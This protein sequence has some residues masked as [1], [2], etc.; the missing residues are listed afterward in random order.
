MTIPAR[1]DYEAVFR[2]E[3]ERLNAAQRAAVERTE[4]PV[5]VLAG[6]G[7]GKTHL[8]AARIGNILLETDTGAHNILCLTFT[9]AGAKAMRDRLLSFIGP[10]AHRIGIFTFHGFCSRVIQDNLQYFGRPGLEPLGELE[11]VRI[12]RRLLDDLPADH[13]LRKGYHDVYQHEQHLQHLFSAM[14]AENWSVDQVTEAVNAFDRGLDTHPDYTYRNNRKGQWTKGDPKTGMIAQARLAMAKLLGGVELFPAYQDALRQL[15]R[16][17]YGDMIGWVL[18]AFHDH[19]SLLR[20]YQERYQY[21]LVD[22]FQDTNGSQDAIV[23]QLTAYWEKPNVFIVGDDDQAIYEFQGARLQAMLDFFHRHEDVKVVTLTENYR[24]RQPIL[25]AAATLISGNKLRIA[26]QLKEVAVDKHLRSGREFEDTGSDPIRW[27]SFSDRNQETAGLLRQLRDWS[28]GGTPWGEMAVIYARHGQADLLRHLL[29]RAGIPYQSKRRPNVLDGRPVRQ[30]REMLRYLNAEFRRPGTGEHLL[31]RILHNRFFKTVPSDLALLNLAR[32][33]REEGADAGAKPAKGPVSLRRYLRQA[34]RWPEDLS[35]R[36]SVRGASDW[37]EATIGEVGSQPLPRLVETVVNGSGLLAGVLHHPE[38][39]ELLQYLASFSDFVLAEVARR[40]RLSLAD[41][42]DTLDQMDENRIALPLRTNLDQGDAVLLVSAHS[43]K[44][45]EFE[46][47]WLL[48]CS[49]KNWGAGGNSGRGQFKLPDT[50]TLSGTED[51]EEAR[52]R[53]FFV[54]LTRART[55]VIASCAELN[56]KGKAQ[57]HVSFLDELPVEREA[58]HV[59][60]AE[61]E[62]LAILQLSPN[63]PARLPAL[64]RSAVAELLTGYRLSVS[65]LYAYLDCPLRFFY[66]KLL[67]VPDRERER[68]LYGSSLH[69]ALQD[70]FN[71]MLR[72][73]DRAFPSKE[74]LL[75]YYELALGRRRGQ[76]LPSAFERLLREGRTEMSRYFDTHRKGWIREVLVEQYLGNVEVDGVPL[77]GMIDRIDLISDA[78][79]RV[80]D[81]KTSSSRNKRISGPTE[82]S[83]NGTDYWRQLTFYKLLF[84]NSPGRI[85]RVR[86]GQISFLLTNP[87]GEQIN[88]DHRFTEKDT[89]ALRTI[90]RENWARIQNQEFTGCGKDDC[91]WCRFEADQLAEVPLRGADPAG[92]DDLT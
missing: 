2:T 54:A 30:L 59:V 53:L 81:Y 18:R 6:P 33:A 37:L 42:L 31:Y 45:L 60:G 38:R 41:L 51:E 4:G 85:H 8:L 56:D 7:T 39:A 55:E 62:A 70:Y 35:D 80:V 79:V 91:E 49:E 88:L 50:L 61:L 36:A 19:P 3:M 58:V 76:L 57:Q 82:R 78:Y 71:R 69:E 47:V 90:L 92:L 1:Q 14:K 16:Y 27:L 28:A 12:V 29:E 32:L 11:Q 17:D 86:D 5:M 84:D 66:E 87:D 40:P 21:L 83:P 73:P 46:K 74:E 26:N 10:E 68:T 89:A 25:D 43:A 77:V 64:E 13:P 9:E 65:G 63:D 34:D 75:Y 20:S 67:R 44:G 48:D 22:E 24:S 52:R 23:R 15:G 72:N